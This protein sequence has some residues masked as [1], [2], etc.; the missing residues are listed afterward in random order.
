MLS[1]PP[2]L[3][4]GPP[5]FFAV[6]V[7]SDELHHLLKCHR[8]FENDIIIMTYHLLPLEKYSPVRNFIQCRSLYEK[9]VSRFCPNILAAPI[10]SKRTKLYAVH[11][12]EWPSKITGKELR[13][14]WVV[15]IVPPSY[16]IKAS[17]SVICQKISYQKYVAAIREHTITK[18]YCERMFEDDSVRNNKPIS[19]WWV[20]KGAYLGGHTLSCSRCAHSYYASESYGSTG[21][22]DRGHHIPALG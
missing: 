6:V 4:S 19:F 16:H 22:G 15:A 14:K 17:R 2:N 18:Y 3:S 10:L 21:Q 5:Q 11:V 13:A 1:L 8:A 7:V 9:R 20:A 12:D